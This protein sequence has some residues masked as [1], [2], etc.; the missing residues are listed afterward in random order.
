MED[1]GRTIYE[2][3]ARNPNDMNMK[4]ARARLLALQ[5]KFQQAETE[6]APLIAMYENDRAYHHFTYDAAVIYAL[7]GKSQTAIKF[8][9]KTVEA[10]MPNY[11]LFTRD[12]HLDRIRKEPAFT[13]FMSDLKTRWDQYQ[14]EFK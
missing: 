6:I 12:P 4:S 10:G 8:L 14:G 13:R 2:G 11:P 7:A 9:K 5:G 3:L 1:A